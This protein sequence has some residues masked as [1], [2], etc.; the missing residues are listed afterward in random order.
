MMQDIQE[1]YYIKLLF[2]MPTFKISVNVLYRQPHSYLSSNAK[3][4]CTGI[5]SYYS[6][7]IATSGLHTKMTMICAHIE[8][9]SA[10]KIIAKDKRM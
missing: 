3:T 6:S 2:K 1:K 9:R 5:D 4:F 7:R 8:E 10:G